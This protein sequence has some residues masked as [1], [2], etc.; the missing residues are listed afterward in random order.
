MIKVGD[1]VIPRIIGIM[2]YGD[3]PY[4]VT[5]ISNDKIYTI[6]QTIKFY[7][8]KLKLPEEKIR[9]A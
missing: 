2:D 1:Y 5:E 8:H 9:K 4:I 7:K 6:V 3:P